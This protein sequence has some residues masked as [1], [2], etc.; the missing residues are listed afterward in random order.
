MNKINNLLSELTVEEKLQLI[1]LMK[2]IIANRSHS[3]CA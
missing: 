2:S 3:D 1:E